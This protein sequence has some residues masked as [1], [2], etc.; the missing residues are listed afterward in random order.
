MR[1]RRKTRHEFMN[2]D[3]RVK[4]THTE[5]C[6]SRAIFCIIG[7]KEKQI[8]RMMSGSFSTFYRLHETRFVIFHQ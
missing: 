3:T 7:V 2:I 5:A 6:F 4:L 8:S 1:G